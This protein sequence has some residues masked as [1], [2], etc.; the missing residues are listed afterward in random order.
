MMRSGRSNLKF[1]SRLNSI[2]PIFIFS[3]S[4]PS[5]SQ[6]SP[7]EEASQQK[8]AT[9]EII[10]DVAGQAPAIDSTK[11]D[12]PKRIKVDG[13]AA[14]V[15]DHVLLESDIDKEFVNLETQGISTKDITRC[16]LLG[17]LMEDKLYAHHAIQDSLPFS[18]DEINARVDQVIQYFTQQLGSMDKV[19]AYYGKTNEADF[20]KEVFDAQKTSKLAADMRDKIVGDIEVTP[21][22]VRQFFNKIPAEDRPLIGAEMEIAQIVVKP[23]VSEQEKQKVINDLKQYRKDVLENG[24]GFASK[25]IL[26]SQD[27]GSRSNGGLYTLDRKRPRMVKEF[28]DV[29][30]SLQPGEVSEPFESDFGWHIITVDKV[31]GQ[32][33]DVRHI[34]RIPKISSTAL[35]GAKNKID[36][37][38]T[39]ILDKEITF[40]EAAKMF[41]DEKETRNNG[42]QLYNPITQDT[43]FELTKM[44][45]TL[46]TQVRELKDG[47]ISYPLVDEDDRGNKRYKILRVTR[48][49]EEHIADFAQDYIKVKELTLKEKQ[50]KAITK[51]MGEKIT[52]TYVKVN[53]EN[54]SC[55]FENDWLKK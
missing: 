14:V 22:E 37:I 47:E 21:E 49:Y 39:R 38:R 45:P 23:K 30:F 5:F 7:A 3:I 44:D 46:Y 34:L 13:V 11:N 28:R 26:Y 10:E 25:A 55:D 48:R 1:M 53:A 4:I 18:D 24:V 41:S 43:H 52:D 33:R 17:K 12:A 42:G 32:Q 20:R 40:E 8:E 2:F 54:R 9:V 29:A 6:D 35:L 50:L 19:L 31:R 36:S 27:P 16:Q 51:W 15:G